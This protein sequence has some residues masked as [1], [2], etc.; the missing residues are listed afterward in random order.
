[1]MSCVM[2]SMLI[3]YKIPHVFALLL[4]VKCIFKGDDSHHLL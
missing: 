1:M 4:I 3:A 2:L